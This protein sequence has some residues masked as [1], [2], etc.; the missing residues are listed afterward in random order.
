[1]AMVLSCRNGCKLKVS[2]PAMS[3]VKPNRCFSHGQNVVWDDEAI[4]TLCPFSAAMPGMSSCVMIPCGSNWNVVAAVVTGTPFS[5][6]LST[7]M[8]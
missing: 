6:A 8:S 5:M 7:W 3:S 4:R 2:T 1:M